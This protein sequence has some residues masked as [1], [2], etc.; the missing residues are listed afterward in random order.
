MGAYHMGMTSVTL[1]IAHYG[2]ILRNDVKCGPH[3]RDAQGQ[4]YYTCAHTI[5]CNQCSKGLHHLK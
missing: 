4:S 5:Q 1:S 2:F 3:Y